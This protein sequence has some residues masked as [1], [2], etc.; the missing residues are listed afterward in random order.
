MAAEPFGEHPA[1]V[2]TRAHPL[3]TRSRGSRTSRP[4]DTYRSGEVA[5]I[6]GVTRR[7]LHY[8]AKTGLVRPSAATSGGHHR[9]RFRDLVALKT[10]KRLIDAGISLQRIRTSID[11]LQRML[12]QVEHPLSELVLVATGDLVLVLHQGTAFEAVSGQEWI[13][14]VAEFQRELAAWLATD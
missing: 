7:Q 4:R 9:Y 8:W 13:F 2:Q 14:D 1:S 5:E 11:A 12:P 6:L 3:H 10:A